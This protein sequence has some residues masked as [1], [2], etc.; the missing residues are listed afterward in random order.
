MRVL[1][2]HG[3]FA[4]YPR[5]ASDISKFSNYF[6]VTLVR[7]RDYYTFEGLLD[8]PNYSLTGFPF[9]NL[10][11]LATFEGEP[12]EV[13]RENGFVY[14]LRLGLI[15]PKLSVIGIVD[16]PLV[17]YYFLAKGSL[18]QPGTRTM[19]GRQILSYSAEFE[20]VG[21]SLKVMEYSYE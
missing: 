10:P 13:M 15:V 8:A 14:D 7:E 21:S 11:A 9:L 1:C 16:L 6:D 12:W 5:K 3:H 4:F 18:V 19:I 17:G 20:D 2:R